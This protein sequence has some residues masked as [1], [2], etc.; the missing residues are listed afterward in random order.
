MS[1]IR[2]EGLLEELR[3]WGVTCHL[4]FDYFGDGWV[5]EASDRYGEKLTI[6]HGFEYEGEI[7]ANADQLVVESSDT[8][9]IQ[10]RL[11]IVTNAR[12][13]WFIQ[14]HAVSKL[15]DLVD[16]RGAPRSPKVITIETMDTAP[17]EPTKLQQAV[18]A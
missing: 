7:F 17:V 13:Q 11:W 4:S 1:F 3:A 5:I 8:K 10:G 14:N 6:H 9:G 15:R 2:L 18:L 16:L 12:L